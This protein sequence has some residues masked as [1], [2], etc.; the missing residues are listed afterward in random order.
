[1]QKIQAQSSREEPTEASPSSSFS[2]LAT[3]SNR[4]SVTGRMVI[5][6]VPGA[7]S[8]T[9]H[10][11]SFT[12][13]KLSFHS[14]QTHLQ[15]NR[16]HQGS[17]YQQELC[18]FA[19]LFVRSSE[20]CYIPLFPAIVHTCLHNPSVCNYLQSCSVAMYVL[21]GMSAALNFFI[22]VLKGSH[23]TTNSGKHSNVLPETEWLY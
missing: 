10:L 4:V 15:I 19:E 5:T 6:P 9:F 11:S 18:V 7:V 22:W 8:L 1:M 3:N 21:V 2:L 14:W 12:W 16:Y 13:E 17:L 23:G 20:N